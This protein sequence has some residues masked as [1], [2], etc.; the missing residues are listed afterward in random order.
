MVGATLAQRVLE[1]GLADVVLV[2][3][4]K[5]IAAGKA[6]DLADASSLAGHERSIVGTGDYSRSV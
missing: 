2:D 5:N 3:I 4:L 1:S 6:L